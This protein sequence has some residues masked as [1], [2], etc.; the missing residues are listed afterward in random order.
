MKKRKTPVFLMLS[1]AVLILWQLLPPNVDTLSGGIVSPALSMT[2]SPGGCYL[3]C[4]QGDGYDLASIGATIS[5][6]VLAGPA[7]GIPIPGILASDFWLVGCTGSLV[8]CGGSGSINADG[9]TD[10]AGFTTISGRLSGGGCDTAGLL[11]V[12]QGVIIGGC[13]PIVTVSPD[14]NGDMNVDL[15][16][17]ATFA[18]SYPS[19][20]K[21]YVACLDFDCSG[22][23][24]LLDFAVFGMHYLH[25]C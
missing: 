25:E 4:P 9:P 8:L 1:A 10:A 23:I 15:I 11:V 12:V 6:T 20:P 17:F 22:A 2:G 16:D 19:P 5:V 24:G 14:I 13:L 18:M 21:P 3:V 7:P